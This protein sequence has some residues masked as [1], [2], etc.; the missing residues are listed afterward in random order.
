MT[1]KTKEIWCVAMLISACGIGLAHAENAKPTPTSPVSSS[2]TQSRIK[3]IGHRLVTPKAN[4]VMVIAHRACWREAPENSVAAIEACAR[5]GVDMV[6]IDVHISSDGHLVI[7][8]DDTVDRTTNGQGLVQDLTL[9]QL[10]ALYLKE[11][12]GG[13]G[14]A[15]TTHRIP[16]LEEALSAARGK[17][18]VNLDAKGPSLLRALAQV[19]ELGWTDGIL[20]KGTDVPPQDLAKF[21][22]AYFMPVVKESFGSIQS[23][24]PLY[25]AYRPVAFEVVYDSPDYLEKNARDV[26]DNGYRLWVNTMWE[27]LAAQTTDAGAKQD[28]DANWGYL[29]TKGVNMI[30]TD[31]PRGLLAYLR[32]QNLRAPNLHK[33]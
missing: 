15:L 1:L 13:E 26:V 2:H 10:K 7:M 18:F 28:P 12:E 8:H 30:Q 22:D 11:A 21:K 32:A 4:D 25:K 23:Q 33:D 27:G 5:I 14:A 19:R 9:A 31:D 3:A 20:F 29:A 16:T 24:L 17:V 6:E